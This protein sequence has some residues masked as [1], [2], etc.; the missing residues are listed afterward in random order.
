MSVVLVI[1]AD[2]LGFAP[3]VNRGIIEAHDAGTLSSASM[4]VNTP[5]F[6]E[7]V[8]LAASRPRLGVGLHLNLVTGRPLSAAPSLTDPRTGTFH[9]LGELARRAFTGRVD[10]ADVRRECD[11]QLRALASAGIIA[12]HLDSHRH[13][14]ALPGILPAVAASASEAGV[15][16][17]RRPLDHPTLRHPAASARMLALHAA[18]RRALID[19]DP[20]HLP[21]LARAPHFRGVALQGA[22]DVETRLLALLDRLP[23][24]TTELML[25]PGHDDAT[26]AAQDPYRQEREREVSALRSPAVRA[27]LERGDVTLVSFAAL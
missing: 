17:V 25:H 10:A 1:N 4:M 26:L 18:W 8:A 20:A 24:G 6:T 22:P 19:V 21:L 14:H 11:A 9:S 16:W 23:S 5:A 7:A 15:H 3:G 12:T 13:A 27:R 2:D